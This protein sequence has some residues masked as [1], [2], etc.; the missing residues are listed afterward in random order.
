MRSGGPPRSPDATW[1]P[2]PTDFWAVTAVL[3]NEA[4]LENRR[5]AFAHSHPEVI[6]SGRHTEPVHWRGRLCPA[7]KRMDMFYRAA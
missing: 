4:K 1:V 7:P 6:S 3:P 2:T 5:S